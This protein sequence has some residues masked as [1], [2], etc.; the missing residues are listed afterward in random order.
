VVLNALRI[1]LSESSR[2]GIVGAGVQLNDRGEY[3]LTTV[4]VTILPTQELLTFLEVEGFPS[5]TLPGLVQG[6]RRLDFQTTSEYVS[7]FDSI[8]SFVDSWS[9]NRYL[10]LGSKA[11]LRPWELDSHDF[12]LIMMDESD[13]LGHYVPDPRGQ[14]SAAEIIRGH[15]RHT[16]VM[17]KTPPWYKRD[18]SRGGW[19]RSNSVAAV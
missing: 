5:T 19:I 6:Y 2:M 8:H 13:F 1:S 16:P 12:H 3:D 14:L 15:Y 17:T 9:K 4:T 18:F 10:R 11:S 7:Y